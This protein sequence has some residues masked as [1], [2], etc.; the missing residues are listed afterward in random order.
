M[1]NLTLWLLLSSAYLLFSCNTGPQAIQYGSEGCH[2]CKMTIVD[3]IHGAELV[4]DKG[5]V[6]K[7]DA[8]ECMVNFFEDEPHFAMSGAYTNYYEQ[9][10]ELL[11]VEEATFLI[12]PNLPSPMGAFLTAFRQREVAE[13]V[14]AE[15][16]GYLFSWEELKRELSKP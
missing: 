16:G 4:S 5:K 15:K 11:L 10:E 3:K 9:P 12:S 7:F 13:Q 8:A 6:F 2:Y 14:K 1:K